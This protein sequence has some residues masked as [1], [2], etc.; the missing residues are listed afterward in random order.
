MDL[1]FGDDVLQL[2]K[3]TVVDKTPDPGGHCFIYRLAVPDAPEG[4]VEM[5]P[6][7]A[8]SIDGPVPVATLQSYGW[9]RADGS[10]I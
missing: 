8:R 1:H 9:R 10:P 7:F 4:A 6:V 2:L 5:D 3:A